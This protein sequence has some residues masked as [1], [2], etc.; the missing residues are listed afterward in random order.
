MSTSAAAAARPSWPT[1]YRSFWGCKSTKLCCTSSLQH[2]SAGICPYRAAVA[3]DCVVACAGGALK[4]PCGL[5]GY[6]HC[7][8][9]D[10]GHCRECLDG[11]RVYVACCYAGGFFA[12]ASKM[13]G[14]ADVT[15][16]R[17]V[18][19][20]LASCCGVHVWLVAAAN[21]G[22]FFGDLDGGGIHLLGEVP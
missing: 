4:R 2:G 12:S 8:S 20:P 9:F 10:R 18:V 7:F 16:D 1:R 5:R 11:L 21:L 17:I 15:Y 22:S 14:T 6:M 3:V 13:H 19:A